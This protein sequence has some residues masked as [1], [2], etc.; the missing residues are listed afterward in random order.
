MLPSNFE[1]MFDGVSNEIA[2]FEV[3]SMPEVA[4]ELELVC[5]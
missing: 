5:C 1:L 4:P 3:F 2:G